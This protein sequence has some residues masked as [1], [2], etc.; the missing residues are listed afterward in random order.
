MPKRISGKKASEEQRGR[1]REAKRSEGKQLATQ[2]AKERN[3]SSIATK[4]SKKTN[5]RRAPNAIFLALG[6]RFLRARV[7]SVHAGTSAGFRRW[8]G[9]V[10]GVGDSCPGGRVGEMLGRGGG[11]GG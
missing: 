1:E 3:A 8:E 6:L 5:S 4:Q 7:E 11:G 9:W 2:E 10:K